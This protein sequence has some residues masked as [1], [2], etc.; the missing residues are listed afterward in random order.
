MIFLIHA[1]PMIWSSQKSFLSRHWIQ[2]LHSEDTQNQLIY[3]QKMKSLP[4]C[5]ATIF[6]GGGL[7]INGGTITTTLWTY[8]MRLGTVKENFAK[9]IIAQEKKQI[10]FTRAIQLFLQLFSSCL[11]NLIGLERCQPNKWC[12]CAKEG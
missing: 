4:N 5:R 3:L 1:L 7:P 2:I 8:G 6:T 10:Y 12:Q 11:H 9:N